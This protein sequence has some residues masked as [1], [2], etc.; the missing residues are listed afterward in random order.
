MFYAFASTFVCSYSLSVQ[1]IAKLLYVGLVNRLLS[2]ALDTKMTQCRNLC[3]SA[4]LLLCSL[5]LFP[6]AGL[7]SSFPWSVTFRRV[8]LSWQ[9]SPSFSV[10][11]VLRSGPGRVEAP[12]AS[13]QKPQCGRGAW[14]RLSRAGLWKWP[15]PPTAPAVRSRL[16]FSVSVRAVRFHRCSASAWGASCVCCGLAEAQTAVVT[17]RVET[18]VCLWFN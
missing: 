12:R 2:Q 8:V 14:T 18:P 1:M 17:H 16:P 7:S 5:I 15:S 13:Q 3:M 11:A 9:G 4:H 10:T 6:K